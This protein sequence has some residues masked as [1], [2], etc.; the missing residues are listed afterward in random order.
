MIGIMMP[1]GVTMT[2][3][4]TIAAMV[5]RHRAWGRSRT[6]AVI[7]HNELVAMKRPLVA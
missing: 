6:K 2:M 1:A 3:A 4:I 5:G 7:H